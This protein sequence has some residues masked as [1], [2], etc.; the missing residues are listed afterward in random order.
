MTSDANSKQIGGDHYKGR[1]IEPWDFIEEHDIPF[2]EGCAIKYLTRWPDK[3]G[4]ADLDKA[5]HFMEK[6]LEVKIQNPLRT[7]PGI[8]DP[9]ALGTHLRDDLAWRAMALRE[10]CQHNTLDTVSYDLV[11]RIYYWES[12]RQL[13]DIIEGLKIYRD[14]Q[15]DKLP[16]I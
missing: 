16:Q 10:Y 11:N 9:L 2:L 12:E 6:V 1:P 8:L 7:G 4:L 14:V 5:T 15:S 13:K 3:G